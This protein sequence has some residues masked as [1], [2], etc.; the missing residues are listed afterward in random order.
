[1]TH[2]PTASERTAGPPR[3]IERLTSFKPGDLHDL[4]DAAEAAIVDGGG[5]GWLTPPPRQVMETYWHGILLVPERDLFAARLDGVICGSAQLLRPARNNEAAARVGTLSTFFLAPWARG[6]G[7]AVELVETVCVAARDAGLEVMQLD[8]RESQA[9]AIQIYEQLGFERWG[10]NPRYAFV[11]GRW[12]VG[13]YY[14][15]D[16]R[17]EGGRTDP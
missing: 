14:H 1:M 3:G 7:L 5:F 2:D 12:M 17:A 15:R 9:R 10:S 4:C 11:E 16:L 13:H 6:H 8:V